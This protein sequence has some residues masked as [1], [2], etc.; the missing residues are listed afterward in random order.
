[1][2]Q[3]DTDKLKE[4]LKSLSQEDLDKLAEAFGYQGYQKEEGYIVPTA[5]DFDDSFANQLDKDDKWALLAFLVFVDTFYVPYLNKLIGIDSLLVNDDKLN[6]IYGPALLLIQD[7][8]LW[9]YK[10]S[11]FDFKKLET[12]ITFDRFDKKYLE[13]YEIGLKDDSDNVLARFRVSRQL[14]KINQRIYKVK[15]WFLDGNEMMAFLDLSRP[16]NYFSRIASDDNVEK[17]CRFFGIVED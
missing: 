15:T 11:D 4:F 10:N 1:M 7:F 13:V 8:R 6:N 14:D 9:D 3:I 2:Y 17:F 5:D 12:Y 16:D